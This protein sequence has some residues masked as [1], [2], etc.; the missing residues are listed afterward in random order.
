MTALLS[1]CSISAASLSASVRPC[2][3]FYVPPCGAHVSRSLWRPR[4][5]LLHARQDS[6]HKL[7]SLEQCVGAVRY[8]DTRDTFARPARAQRPAAALAGGALEAPLAPRQL[9]RRA[10]LGHSV[11]HAFAQPSHGCR[12]LQRGD[13]RRKWRRFS[14]PACPHQK[15]RHS[16]ACEARLDMTQTKPYVTEA[17]RR[18]SMTVLDPPTTP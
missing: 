4:W 14:S 8:G 6:N 18:I 16:C 11:V 15:Q 3:G 12:Q 17:S 7:R 9:P 10:E 5:Q 13:V 2:V 1:P